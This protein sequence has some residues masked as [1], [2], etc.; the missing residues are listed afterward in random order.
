MLTTSEKIRLLL[1]RKD[2][3]IST[4]AE[5]IGTS[6]QNLN[7]KLRRNNFSELDLKDIANA[8]EQEIIIKFKDVGTGGE[9]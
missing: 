8:L 6:R 7:N 3:S 4:L 1:K 5:K 9:L 2:M